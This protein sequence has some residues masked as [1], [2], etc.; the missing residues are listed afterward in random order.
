MP[1]RTDYRIFTPIARHTVKW[2]KAYNK[3]TSVERVNARIDRVLGFEE[4]FIRG[5][6]KMQTRVTLSLIVMLAM[7]LGRI[8][9]NQSELMRSI[10][11]PVQKLA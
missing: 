1:L 7:A 5:H 3:R 2:K 11:K 4:H 6:K 10:T 9:A 8:R